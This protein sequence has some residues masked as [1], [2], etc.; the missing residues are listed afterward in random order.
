MKIPLFASL[1][2][3]CVWLTFSITRSR[4]KGERAERDFWEREALADR[5]RKQPLDTLA[6]IEIPYDT[7]PF[8]LIPDDPALADA[9]S[10]CHR[11]LYGFRD[12]KAVNLTGIS[13]TDL[14]LTYGAPNIT[15]LTEYDDNYTLLVRTMQKW[16]D[17]LLKAG[18]QEEAVSVMEFCIATRTDISTTYR[19]L[20]GIY[21]ERGESDKLRG[22]RETADGLTSIMR[23]PILRMLDE[24]VQ[25]DL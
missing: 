19:T 21:H 2:L 9:F 10:D 13:N 17:L 6:Y 8:S 25:G 22:L 18:F 14:K 4:R 12:K 11:I 1:I 23:Q 24:T 15:I 16:A 20:A 7:L 3:F 5:T